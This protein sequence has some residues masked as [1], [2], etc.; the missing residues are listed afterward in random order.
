VS[1]QD[2]DGKLGV[3][4][5]ENYIEP[6]PKKTYYNPYEATPYHSLELLFQARHI[7][8]SDTIVDFGCGKG[9]LNFFAHYFYEAAV[10][11]IEMNEKYYLQALENKESYMKKMKNRQAHLDF[12][13]CLAEQYAIQPYENYFYFFHPFSVKIFMAVVS[14]ILY[15]VEK[16]PRPVELILYYAPTDYLV[17]LKDYSPFQLVDQIDVPNEVA[18]FDEWDRFLIYHLASDL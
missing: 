11:G 9:R 8:E 14:N 3:S 1:K 15:S 12:H 2:Y 6:F 7:G 5:A 18:Y 13:C 17:F 4:T 10:T 16:H